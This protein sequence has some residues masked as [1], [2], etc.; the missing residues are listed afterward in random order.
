MDREGSSTEESTLSK[1]AIKTS[2]SVFLPSE[3]DAGGVA[4][5]AD[6]PEA[7]LGT[8]EAVVDAVADTVSPEAWPET[9]EVFL[10]S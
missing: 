2:V 1:P 3:L 7:G 8:E 9:D 10:L 6:P 4:A 5:G